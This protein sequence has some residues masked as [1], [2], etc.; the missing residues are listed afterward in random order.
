MKKPAPWPAPGDSR[1]HGVLAM[2][3]DEF[4]D[5]VRDNRIEFHPGPE[6]GERE[7]EEMFAAVRRAKPG[8]RKAATPTKPRL[9]RGR[10]SSHERETL[11]ALR[12]DHP[13]DCKAEFFALLAN[14]GVPKRLWA[15]KYRAADRGPTKLVDN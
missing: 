10:P 12:R 7:F 9:Q 4:A 11:A 13:G 14:H 3:D 15:R 5:F 2:S 1:V 8:R 6:D